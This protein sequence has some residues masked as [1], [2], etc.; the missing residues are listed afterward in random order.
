MLV[1]LIYASTAKETVDIQEFKR[2]LLQAQGNNQR[3]DLTGML[4]FNSKVFLQALEGDRDKI[5]DLYGRLMRDPR[6]HSL[7]ILKFA[8][9][10]ERHW[11]NWSMGFAAPNA[12]NR[13][14]FLK[15]STQSVFNPYGMGAN[16]VEN[17]L[18]RLASSAIALT[19]PRTEVDAR[20]E[21]GV[22]AR[23]LKK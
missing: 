17:L 15:N 16:A 6:H 3:R 12:D 4:V 9:I 22:F 21:G 23:F 5:N 14:L 19:A 2:I 7:A 10:E 1:R 13:A 20:K 18:M 11:A 8:E